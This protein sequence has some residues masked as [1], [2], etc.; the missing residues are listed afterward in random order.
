M[1]YAR[2]V[3]GR[4]VDCVDLDIYSPRPDWGAHDFDLLDRIF[5]A[6]GGHVAFVAV[7]DDTQN[8]MEQKEDG[9]YGWP[10]PAP[11]PEAVLAEVSKP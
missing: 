8:G 1:K 4:T 2:I 5:A 11:E 7:P 9:S 3:S 10:G 6:V